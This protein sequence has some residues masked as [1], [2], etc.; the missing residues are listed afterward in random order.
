MD[1]DKPPSLHQGEV[2]RLFIELQACEKFGINP[3]TY[4]T[5][6]EWIEHPEIKALILAYHQ[7]IAAEE[8]RI[9]KEIKDKSS[10]SED[11]LDT[12]SKKR[13]RE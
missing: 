2:T 10:S 12:I 7:L 1:G 11:Q 13:R 9:H 8:S 3:L 4:L 6:I 5:S